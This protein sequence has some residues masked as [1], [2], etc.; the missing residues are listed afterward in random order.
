MKPLT[1]KNI[2]S[3]FFVL[4]TV[5]T[6]SACGGGESESGSDSSSESSSSN[7]SNVT[8]NSIAD[9]SATFP[10]ATGTSTL[11]APKLSEECKTPLAE[12]LAK[13]SIHADDPIM[14]I[15]RDLA[16]QCDRERNAVYAYLESQSPNRLA[17]R[18]T[19]IAPLEGLINFESPHVHP[20]DIT[21]NGNILVSVN[22]AAHK[23]EV[24]SI[25]GSSIS[26]IASIPVGLD[27]V[28]VRVRNNSEAWVVNHMSDS[29]S[30]VDLDSETVIRTLKTDNEP[31]DVVFAANR[32]FVSASEANSI[33]VFSLNNLN[34]NPSRIK[35]QG[36]E[37]RALSVSANGSTVYAAIYES[38]NGTTLSGSA[39]GG[40]AIVRSNQQVDNDVA[41]INTSSLQVSYRRRLM[42]MV[43]A[44]G[45]NPN[46]QQVYAVGTEAFNDIAGEPALNGKFIKVNMARFSGSGLSGSVINDLNPHLNYNNPTVS[47]SLRQQS[48]GDPRSIV[49]QSNGQ[50]A[51]IAGMGSNNVIVIDSSGNRVSNF[52]VGQGPTGIVLKNG[53][54]FGFV[55]NKFAG[56]I[57]VIDTD[58]LNQIS[59]TEFNDPTPLVI[60]EGR[61]FLYDTHLTSGTGHT[62]CASCHV[63]SRTD[64][65]GWQ[66]SDGNNS[67]ISIPRASNS[68]PGNVIGTSTISSNKQ[69]M[70]TQTLV[71]IMEHPRFHWR[72]DKESIDDF[73]GTYVNLMGRP[74]QIS[75]SQ[76]DKMKAFLRTLW[77][78][79][80]PY[81]R[82]DNSRPSTVT[83]PDGSTATSNR[84]SGNTTNALRGGGNSNNCLA[85]HSGQGNATRNFGAN[86]EIGSNIIAPTLPALYDKIGFSF[87]RTGFGFF[88]DGGSDLDRA[89]RTREF[90]AEIMTLEGP[91][92]PLVG[93][94]ARQAPHAGVGQQLTI[95]GNASSTQSILLNQFISIANTSSWA[96]L[97]AH[98]QINGKQRG[99]ALQ[100]GENFIAD[101]AGE[102]A[103][104]NSLLSQAT[105]GNSVTFTLVATGMSTRLALDSDLNGVLNNDEEDDGNNGDGGD[106]GFTPTID[107]NLSEWSSSQSLGFDGDD[108]NITNSKAD[109][110]EAWASNDS[111]NFYVAYLNDGPIDNDTWWPWQIF[112]DTDG[113]ASTGYQTSSG[114][115]A[116]Y[117][118][119]ASYLMK[120]TGS[121]SDWSWNFQQSDVGIK[122]DDSAEFSI[123]RQA[124]GNPDNLQL[125]FNANNSPFTGISGV[126]SVDLFPN[127][128]AIDY[129]FSTDEDGNGNGGDGDTDGISNSFTPTLDGNL[130]DWS[131]ATSFGPDGNDINVTN[132]QADWLEAWMAHDDN[133]IY[134]AYTND[135]PINYDTWW[136]WQTFLDTDNNPETGY[137]VGNIGADFVVEGSNIA[138]YTGDGDNW[139]WDWLQAILDSG[140]S[141][142]QVELSIPRSILGNIGLIKLHMSTRNVAFTNDFSAFGEDKYEGT[143]P[144]MEYNSSP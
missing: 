107:G 15:N 95:T 60:K 121:G 56:S 14:A 136:P 18:S 27:P 87:G 61:P 82:I 62:S 44:I 113:N 99:F 93:N 109:I 98:S 127:S 110:I 59:E 30:I 100:Q 85:C 3:P 32:A 41:L 31:S 75:Q 53:T 129:D 141:T 57:S 47:S 54:D 11:V 111:S 39:G 74:S 70:V 92:G 137:K 139:S 51:F 28:S 144:I 6:L 25:S 89:T 33:N 86:P 68:L 5:I 48:I 16:F 67:T 101:A 131:Q 77:L 106:N 12:E 135:G 128:G 143:Q 2:I 103:T 119:E 58:S 142:S 1:L 23:L 72:G 4:F 115:G 42:N 123:S 84:I 45:V 120:Y 108:I 90:L 88:H 96:E 76:M 80:N 97:I 43:M 122:D 102:T 8:N 105:A 133:F 36:E 19:A 83:L 130:D 138:S 81:R 71:D 78:P 104:K 79:P 65:L 117:I 91:E 94:E 49:W 46:S 40:G 24:W 38:G 112:I 116:E 37:P 20:I 134:L 17:E 50:R 13:I 34:A 125:V 66:L 21:P 26:P 10:Q 69:V 9:T 118:I 22:T 73:N 124:L 55:M 64:R 35:I 140:Q 126:G 63:D 132:A 52:D 7:T 114:L 29:V